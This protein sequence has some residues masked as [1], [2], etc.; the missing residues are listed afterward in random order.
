MG[1]FRP[2]GI[3]DSGSGGLAIAQAIWRILPKQA[4]IYLADLAYF[5]Y[6]NK[7][8]AVINRRLRRLVAWLIRQ[9]CQL[10]VI[11]CNTITAA[12]I[13]RLRRQFFL[14]FVGTEPAVR[15]GGVVLATPATVKSRRFRQ[16]IKKFPVTVLG[17][18]GLAEAIEAGKSIIPLLPPLPSGTKQIILGCTH[19]LLVKKQIQAVYGPKIN[20]IDPSEAIARQTVKLLPQLSPGKRQ[21]FTTGRKVIKQDIIFKP[22][23]I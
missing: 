6:G 7:T 9:R 14:P 5:P 19:Y 8:P 23:R 15:Q 18:P 1:L 22:C 2:I 20:L 12:A 11:A 21:F 16:L 4:T 13:D 10:I 17:C 3:I